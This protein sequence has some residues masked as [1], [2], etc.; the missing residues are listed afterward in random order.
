MSKTVKVV[1]KQGKKVIS[2]RDVVLKPPPLY[3]RAPPYDLIWEHLDAPNKKFFSR[4]VKM[5]Q[6]A[7]DYTDDEINGFS[8]E[9]IYQ[10]FTHITEHVNK[11]K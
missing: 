1:I 6:A 7:T 9:E 10:L 4:C 2:E 11:K 5:I 8:N 3:G